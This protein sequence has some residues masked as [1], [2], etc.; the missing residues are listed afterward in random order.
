M[1]WYD[2][3]KLKNALVKSVYCKIS[4]FRRDVNEIFSLVECY[5]A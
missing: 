4:G 2:V 3:L 1:Q 5:A